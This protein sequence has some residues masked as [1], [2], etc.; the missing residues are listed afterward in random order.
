[1]NNLGSAAEIRRLHNQVKAA[2]ILAKW[3]K[4]L[5]EEITAAV[6]LGDKEYTLLTVR[7]EKEADNDYLRLAVGILRETLAKKDYTIK[8]DS[9]LDESS[10]L[11]RPY[12]PGRYCYQAIIAWQ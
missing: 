10:N 5:P 1:M 11:D 8:E 4:K 12:G 7:A 9:W 3:E 6:R 2:E